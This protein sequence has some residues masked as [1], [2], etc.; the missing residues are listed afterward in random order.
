MNVASACGF[1][2][3]ARKKQASGLISGNLADWTLHDQWADIKSETEYS[4][5]LNYIR[6]NIEPNSGNAH[7]FQ[8]YLDAQLKPNAEYTFSADIRISTERTGSPQLK[9]DGSTVYSGVLAALDDT[10]HIASDT[11][12]SYGVYSQALTVDNCYPDFGHFS[13]VFSTGGDGVKRLCIQFGKLKDSGSLVDWYI[14]QIY[15][16]NIKVTQNRNTGSV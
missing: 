8:Y 14:H 15:V 11:G 6:V 12:N 16:K 9:T 4:E 13:V 10:N 1:M 7:R 5:E 2:F 3:T